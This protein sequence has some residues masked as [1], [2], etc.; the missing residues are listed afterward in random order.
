M[1]LIISLWIIAATYNTSLTYWYFTRVEMRPFTWRAYIILLI[2]HFF[3]WPAL[4]P[5]MHVY[6]FLSWYTAG[7]KKLTFKEFVQL[8]NNPYGIRRSR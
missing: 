5:A 2:F 7:K 1:L 6:L 4:L 3:A 8:L